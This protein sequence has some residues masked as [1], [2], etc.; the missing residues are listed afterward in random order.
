MPTWSHSRLSAYEDCPQ[1]YEFAYVQK[2]PRIEE[3]VEAFLGSRVHDAL[4]KLYKDLDHKKE[5]SLEELL[6]YFEREWGQNWSDKVK[7]VRKEYSQENYKRMGYQYLTD[8]YKRY[9]PFNQEK[10]LGLEAK[11]EIEIGDGEKEKIK[12]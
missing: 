4:E 1:R 3:G 11:I 2:L 9:A 8:Y 7:I 12:G 5:T 10:T 6:S